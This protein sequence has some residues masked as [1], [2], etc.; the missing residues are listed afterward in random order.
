[1][2][3]GLL[4]CAVLLL[5]IFS[6]HSQRRYQLPSGISEREINPEWIIVKIKG[7]GTDFSNL[8]N[9]VQLLHR[10]NQ[11]KP[12]ILD[13]ICK[14]KVRTDQDPVQLINELLMNS[15]VVY[16]E[17]IVSYQPLYTP[18]DPANGTEQSYLDQIGAYDAWD[19]TRGD[20]DIVIG[21]IDTGVDLDH[22]DLQS[23]IWVNEADPIDGIDNDNNGYIDDYQGYDFADGDN[24]PTADG[25]QHGTRVAGVAGASTDNGIGMSGIG[26]N[27]KI[28]ALKG[29]TT[30]GTLS[31]NL[32]DAIV[33]AGDMGIQVLNLS[34]GSAR[35]PLQSEQDILNYAVLEKD[36]VIAV[37]AGNDGATS[38]PEALFYPASYDNVLSVAGV[39]AS[40]N[41][42]TTSTY[43]YLIDLAAP[44]AS[45]YSTVNDN[46]YGNQSGTSFASPLVA[47]VAA[48]VRDAFPDL[49]ALQVME[50]VR[51]SSDDI[52]GIGTNASFDGK[53]GFG[54]LNAF[55]A[56][57]QEDLKSVRVTSLDAQTPYSENLFFGDTVTITT[58]LTNFLSTTDETQITLSS[59]END[60]TIIEGTDFQTG[61]NS[62]EEGEASFSIVL[63]DDLD[64]ETKFFAR[65]DFMDGAYN[66][67]QHIQLST[68]PD[69]F[70]FGSGLKMTIAGNGNLGFGDI[71]FY[72]GIGSEFD[73][74]TILTYAGIL[75][76]TS[77][78]TVSDNII[79]D[80]ALEN[81]EQDFNSVTNYKLLGH[82]VADQFGYSEFEDPIN[83]LIIEQSSYSWTGSNYILLRY[84]VINNSAAQQ[85]D[86]SVGFFTD[87]DL[88][89]LLKNKASYDAANNYMFT[90]NLDET[91]FAATKII[92]NGTVG[93]SALDVSNENGNS[94][95][96][97]AAFSDAD[98]F[99]FLKNQFIG[100]A[101]DLGDGND[102]AM[103]NGVTINQIDA[104]E[105]EYFTVLVAAAGTRNDL[106]TELTNA[107]NRLDEI[108]ANPRILS[109]VFSCDSDVTI[110]PEEGETYRFYEDPEGTIQLHEGTAFTTGSITTDT[111]FYV[112]N[113]DGTYASDIFQVQVKLIEDV[114]DF[115]MQPDTLYLDHETN[116][117]N[118]S[119]QSFQATTWSW[120]F[121]QGTTSSIQNPSLSFNQVGEYE[122]SLFIENESDCTDTAIKNLV[123]ANRPDSPVF[124]SFTICPGDNVMLSDPSADF[125]RVF[126]TNETENHSYKGNDLE[127]GPFYENSTIYVSGIYS[128]FESLRIPIEIQVEEVSTD[129]TIEIDTTTVSHQ[130]IVK[131]PE[132]V[133]TIEWFVND[134]SI[135]TENQIVIDSSTLE[136]TIRL[137][138]T[139]SN[140]CMVSEEKTFVFSSS[141]IP[142]QQDVN[143]CAN[144]D[145]I[146]KPQNGEIFGFYND[147]ELTD[148][149]KKG[150]EF[151]VSE[152][153][154]IFVVGL[155]DGLPSDPREV[156]ITFEEFDLEIV[157]STEKI[158]N[159]HQVSLSTD[160]VEG[161]NEFKWY[162][163]GEQSASS[164]APVFVLEETQHE[165]VVEIIND[166][167]CS[168]SDTLQ[169]DLVPPL[170]LDETDIIEIYPNPSQ[171]FITLFSAT[172]I[173]N[174]VVWDMAGNYIF[175]ITDTDNT[176]DLN[177]L[178]SGIYLLKL[179]TNEGVF[180]KKLIMK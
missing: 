97:E 174:V 157:S 5:L 177:Q 38:D 119:D 124:S 164:A 34:W 173:E 44:G 161:I 50:Q 150:T 152:N 12:S 113:M 85:N 114:A 130:I 40:D 65:F 82:P 63:N 39:D 17:P 149:V 1:M 18:S 141:S 137:E 45:L 66:D 92:A 27:S 64:P 22:E 70:D 6:V 53:L 158:G 16:A 89:N 140:N 108:I 129:F 54:R 136:T 32:F 163:N 93:Y 21:I 131:A 123:V 71:Y 107:Q 167:G 91:V 37:S 23:S 9:E 117:V 10:T 125:L 51:V 24:D 127:V 104:F 20:D 29:F 100:S 159:R 42:F 156:N 120:D 96:V 171:G 78:T 25:N 60:F 133:E 112:K 77:E 80:Y 162:V 143:F 105:S 72:E 126:D 151:E 111:A 48:L 134:I 147:A 146:L 47:G 75:T 81:R 116:V 102:V 35:E 175:E 36:V 103:L 169:L 144:E 2:M 118:F 132:G 179:K 83:N 69:H 86:V 67:F 154:K 142:S 128:Q 26:F 57:S 59:P 14:I 106:E 79:N 99:D 58:N 165:I 109:S 170:A 139:N 62:L 33:Y 121:D 138:H 98:K 4:T 19:I 180:N 87:F 178:N 61:L 52:Y 55:S 153:M 95:D 7:D 68:S 145:P 8:P 74:N 43:N 84:R 168:H 110:D 135:G 15:N 76:A 94:F 148:L 11:A 41:R 3:R 90:N 122:I 155:D 73:G 176:I 46:T 166:N 172:I 88:D 101:G 30:S 115:S 49:N 28:A 56:V 160:P 13:G 31:V